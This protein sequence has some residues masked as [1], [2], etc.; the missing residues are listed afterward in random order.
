[1]GR[2]LWRSLGGGDDR[3][4]DG[5]TPRPL[6]QRDAHPHERLFDQGG[7]KKD[8]PPDPTAFSWV[9]LPSLSRPREGDRG[10][11]KNAGRADAGLSTSGG[12]VIGRSSPRRSFGGKGP[13]HSA[14][15]RFRASSNGNPAHPFRR[16]FFSQSD[17]LQPSRSSPKTPGGQRPLCSAAGKDP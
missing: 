7:W 17:P 8:S 5:G 12:Q 6:L 16:V 11:P 13:D 15:D 14:G 1:M 4:E 2:I 10:L 9:P 3:H